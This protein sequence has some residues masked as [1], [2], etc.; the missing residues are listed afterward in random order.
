VAFEEAAGWG[1]TVLGTLPSVSVNL[2][3][4]QLL[5]DDLLEIVGSDLERSGL[6]PSR[7]TVELTEHVLGADE[8]LV[9]QRLDALRSLGIRLALD[10]FGTGWSSLRLVR[11]MPFDL[12]KIDRTFTADVDQSPEGAE[13]AARIVALARSMGRM[14]VAE[15]IEREAQ[16]Q[17]MAAMGCQYG[18]GWLFGAPVPPER[19]ARRESWPTHER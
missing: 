10:D 4:T 15:G 12:I 9:A 13:F 8:H 16:L 5:A 3:V 14:V 11:T 19:F 2:S 7:V 6:D 18:Q 1:R 17:V